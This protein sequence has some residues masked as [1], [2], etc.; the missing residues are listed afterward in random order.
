MQFLA[1]LTFLS[2]TLRDPRKV[3]IF[4]IVAIA[5]ILLGPLVND[6]EFSAK[7]PHG[8]ALENSKTVFEDIEALCWETLENTEAS[9]CAYWDFHNGVTSASG[10]PFMKISKR[11]ESLALGIAPTQNTMQD[12][13]VTVII[14]WISPFLRHECVSNIV[15]QDP[16]KALRTILEQQG[17]KSYAVCPVFLKG[18]REPVGYVALAYSIIPENLDVAVTALRELSYG[19]EAVLNRAL[20]R[21]RDQ[22]PG[23][24]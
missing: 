2:K 1:L 23:V 17:T 19:V 16:N 22:Q 14:D 18:K 15:A 9:R 8:V 20:G 5:L 4:S 10:L 3:K 12:V 11:V 6:L 13:P 24:K 21:V 7:D